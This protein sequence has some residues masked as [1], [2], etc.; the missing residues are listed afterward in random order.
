MFRKHF[1]SCAIHERG[2]NR[3]GVLRLQF[4]EAAKEALIFLGNL[5]LFQRAGSVIGNV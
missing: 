5:D 2:T 1:I 3:L 4:I